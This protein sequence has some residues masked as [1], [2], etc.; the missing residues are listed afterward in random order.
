MRRTGAHGK[1][2]LI[3]VADFDISACAA[4]MLRDGR[5]RA[6]AFSRRAFSRRT[7]VEFC[8]ASRAVRAIEASRRDGGERRLSRC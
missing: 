3:E 7:R 2:R 1:L 6:I 4:L 5:D 8:A